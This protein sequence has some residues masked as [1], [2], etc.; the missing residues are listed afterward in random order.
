MLLFE[1]Q[2]HDQFVSHKNDHEIKIRNNACLGFDVSTSW[3]ILLD[4]FDLMNKHNF[5]LIIVL[6]ISWKMAISISWNSTSWS[7][8][9]NTGSYSVN[10]LLIKTQKNS[11]KRHICTL[12]LS[13]ILRWKKCLSYLNGLYWTLI[14]VSVRKNNKTNIYLKKLIFF[15]QTWQ[16]QKRSVRWSSLQFRCKILVS[17]R[18][19]RKPNWQKNRLSDIRKLIGEWRKYMFEKNKFKDNEDLSESDKTWIEKF[20]KCFL[21]MSPMKV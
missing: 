21:F 11:N 6:F 12:F 13:C 16:R 2:S 14:V 10:W 4:K 5:D 18:R 20:G 19:T 9:L 17:I 7:L 8:P 3:S 15:L 1:F